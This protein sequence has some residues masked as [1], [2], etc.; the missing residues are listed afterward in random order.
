MKTTQMTQLYAAYLP[1]AG[2]LLLA[3]D[4][5]NDEAQ[6]SP[7]VTIADED[8]LDGPGGPLLLRAAP[9]RG[10]SVGSSVDGALR[11][12]AWFGNQTLKRGSTAR[13]AA[14][15]LALV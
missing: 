4:P 5:S 3:P 6:L 13:S 1:D 2:P 11:A 10:G 7:M 12:S 9:G 14:M 8:G 15:P